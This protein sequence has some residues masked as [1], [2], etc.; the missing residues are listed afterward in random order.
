MNSNTAL[1][2]KRAAVQKTIIQTVW[3]QGLVDQAIMDGVMDTLN[4]SA[5]WK[6]FR[7]TSNA[8]EK[9]TD[10]TMDPAN[11]NI[12]IHHTEIHPRHCSTLGLAGSFA[13]R[14]LRQLIG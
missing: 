14:K 8:P 6:L 13:H 10:G 5:A 11:L 9:M 2:S 7:S 1:Q 4:V 12:R 3:R